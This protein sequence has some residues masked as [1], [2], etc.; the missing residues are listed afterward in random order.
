[1]ALLGHHE[2]GIICY[3][4]FSMRAR[5]SF[6]LGVLTEIQHFLKK[7]EFRSF[8]NYLTRLN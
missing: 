3:Q 2:V 7:V 8:L 1:M 5:L 6:A 4:L